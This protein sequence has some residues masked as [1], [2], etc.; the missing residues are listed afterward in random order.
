MTSK[1]TTRSF[2]FLTKRARPSCQ[3]INSTSQSSSIRQISATSSR[4]DVEW[5]T[6]K[7][8]R[9]RWAHTPERMK[10][11]YSIVIKDP[12]RIWKTNTDPAKLDRFYTNFLGR[13]G[14]AVL[15]D[16][17]K[18]LAVTHKSFDQGRRGFNDRLAFFGR[19]I[20]ATQ[21]QQPVY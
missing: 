19:L 15:T 2:Q 6:E 12:A 1:A 11:P 13:G 5:E 10:A 14:D 4:R 9:P 8:D 21:L 17:V 3:C 20:P 16:E 7:G 18:W